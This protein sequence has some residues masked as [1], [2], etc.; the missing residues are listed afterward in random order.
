VAVDSDDPIALPQAPPPRP[1]ARRAAIEAALR[2]FDG[3]EDAPRE[4][5][6]KP[7]LWAGLAGM[8]RR[9]TGA[10]VTAA[11]IA[12]VSI[13]VVLTTVRDNVPLSVTP[14]PPSAAPPAEVTAEADTPTRPKTDTPR[15]AEASDV[16]VTTQPTEHPQANQPVQAEVVAP[17]VAKSV[18][19]GTLAAERETLQAGSPPMAA[20]A[21]PPPAP[22]PPP[23][24]PPAPSAQMAEEAVSADDLVVTG[25]RVARP[26]LKSSSPVAVIRSED[27]FLSRLQT[28]IRHDDRATIIALVALPLRVNANGQTLT[29]R[30][31]QDVESDF[32]KIF[33]NRVKQ[34]VLNQRSETLRSRG[35]LKGT[36]RVWFG[37]TSPNGPLR[38]REVTP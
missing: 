27:G 7:P 28:A 11:L 9:A 31:A 25:S 12:V 36:S 8:D 33:T 35:K 5:A 1:A 26:S 37:Q 23:P 29:Y 3:V 19:T 32:E 15:P 4:P 10:L 22:P 38:I 14:S 18:Q 21:P 24:P 34:S 16:P 20:A 30:S 6:R 13:P 17:P 2:K